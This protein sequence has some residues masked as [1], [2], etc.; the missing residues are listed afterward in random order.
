MNVSDPMLEATRFL[1]TNSA[2]EIEGFKVA[3][4]RGDA[5]IYG[6]PNGFLR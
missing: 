6:A 2:E 4:A 3:H 1:R 5:H